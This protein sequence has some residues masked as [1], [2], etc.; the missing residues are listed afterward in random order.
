MEYKFKPKDEYIEGYILVKI[1]SFMERMKILQKA[2]VSDLDQNVSKMFEIL[3]AC[4]KN[5]IEINI[6]IDGNKCHDLDSLTSYEGGLQ[7]VFEALGVIIGGVPNEKKRQAL[8]KMEKKR[9][10]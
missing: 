7:T 2:G 10:G 9:A 6:E 8:L 1:P 3:E 4:S 5:F